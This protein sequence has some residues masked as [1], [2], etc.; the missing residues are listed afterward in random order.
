MSHLQNTILPLVLTSLLTACGSD[1]QSVVDDAEHEANAVLAVKEHIDEEIDTLAVAVSALCAAAPAADDDGWNAS[2]DAAA[3]EA[4]RGEWKK[5][6]IAYEGMEGAIAVVFPDLDYSLDARYDAFIEAAAD[7]NLFDDSGV[8]GMHAVE[9][10]LW[11]N[12]MPAHVV[13]FESALPNYKAA[14]FP[15][16]LAEAGAFKGSLCARMVTDVESMRTQ[17]KDLA[18][19]GIAA[20]RGVTGSMAE[21]AEKVIKAATGEEESRYARFTMADMRANVA[22]G[23]IMSSAFQPWLQSKEGGADL[24]AKITAGFALLDAAIAK[25]PGEGIPEVPEGWSSEAPTAAMLATPFGQLFTVVEEQSDAENEGS[26][27][28]SLTKAGDLIGAR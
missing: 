9:R 27:V 22:A 23:K 14:A 12:E 24:D 21:Q 6:R 15:A 1:N 11:A 4:M 20:Y 26:L 2:D 3:V 8:T 16:T 28:A 17:W 7:T 13:T 18:L 10:I 5:A 25:H 19:D